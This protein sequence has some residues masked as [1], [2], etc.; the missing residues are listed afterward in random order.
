[1][2]KC[3]W[4]ASCRGLYCGVIGRNILSFDFIMSWCGDSI[5]NV[6]S[7]KNHIILQPS[8]RYYT[9]YSCFNPWIQSTCKVKEHYLQTNWR[10]K[11]YGCTVGLTKTLSSTHNSINI[12]LMS[13]ER[14][15]GSFK[16]LTLVLLLSIFH[17]DHKGWQK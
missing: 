7:Y 6:M 13:V 12:M 15:V 10:Q 9:I 14:T 5:Y 2:Q 16:K 3:V 17:L 4:K 1:M 8:L 11:L